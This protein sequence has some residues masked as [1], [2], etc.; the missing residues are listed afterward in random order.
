LYEVSQLVLFKVN[1]KEVLFLL[2]HSPIR[3]YD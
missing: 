3:L 1:V 2:Y